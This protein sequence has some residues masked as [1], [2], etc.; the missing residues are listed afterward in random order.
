MMCPDLLPTGRDSKVRLRLNF[1]KIKFMR[2]NKLCEWNQGRAEKKQE[3]RK[4]KEHQEK[5]SIKTESH[6]KVLQCRV[7]EADCSK[8]QNHHSKG[9]VSSASTSIRDVLGQR[10]Y[11][12]TGK[13]KNRHE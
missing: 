2:L 3:N 4:N 1:L 8:V 13:S 11:V 10:C 12:R 6:F 5:K 9:P 7:L